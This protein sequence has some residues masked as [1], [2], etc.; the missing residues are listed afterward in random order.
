MA[1]TL[2]QIEMARTKYATKFDED[3]QQ[4]RARVQPYTTVETGVEGERWEFPV[5]GGTEMREYH[6]TRHVIEEDD[7]NFE[8]RSMRK[9]KHYNAIPISKDEVADMMNLDYTFARIT[10]AQVAACQRS[11][12]MTA[13]GVVWDKALKK[14]RLKTSADG[15]Y[16]G[17]ILGTNYAGEGGLTLKELDLA[18]TG[19]NLVPVDFTTDG[20]GVSENLAGTIVDKILFVKQRLEELDVFDPTL[21]GS[22]NVAISPFVKRLL[23]L[24]EVRNNADYAFAKLG[25]SGETTF[26]EYLGVNFIVTNMLPTMTTEDKLGNQIEN[27]RMCCVWLSNRVGFGM[28]KKTEFEMLPV[29]DKV[30]VRYR[31]LVTAHMGCARKDEKSVF[32]MPMVES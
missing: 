29:V 5:I 1:L 9:R 6:D 20:T 32:V 8:K 3:F 10:K 11:M 24:Y 31:Q 15:G 12:D 16:L 18:Y 4:L 13:L 30:D 21:K 22:I 23:A 27:A 7:V 2:T 25:E 19:A 28:W 14:Y 17:G 26:N